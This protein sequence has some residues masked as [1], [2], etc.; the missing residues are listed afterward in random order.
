MALAGTDYEPYG[1]V[2]L[3]G[4][5]L[6]DCSGEYFSAYSIGNYPAVRRVF[7]YIDQ[8]FCLWGGLLFHL[9][10]SGR[11]VGALRGG[12]AS[13]QGPAYEAGGGA[14]GKGSLPE[15]CGCG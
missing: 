15:A 6:I 12:M 14:C 9:G 8:A 11:G 1:A 5:L 10:F 4:D 13:Q 7:D 3:S 2:W